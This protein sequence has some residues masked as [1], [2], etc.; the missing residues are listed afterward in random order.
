MRVLSTK[1]RELELALRRNRG[2]ELTPRW[3]DD[4]RRVTGVDVSAGLL[5]LDDTE[6]LKR[7]FVERLQSTEV[8][9]REWPLDQK[10]EVIGE[11]R[12]RIGRAE[13]RITTDGV[14]RDPMA[15]WDLVENDLMVVTDDLANGLCLEINYYTREGEYAKDG[16]YAM[17]TWGV[18]AG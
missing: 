17:T 9:Y 1:S 8:S 5:P 7:A 12:A 14:T 15:V 6:A 11:V 10:D 18:F 16:V 3:L 4:F 13:F 2:K